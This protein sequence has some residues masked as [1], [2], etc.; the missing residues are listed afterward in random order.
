M[1]G[2]F[3]YLTWIIFKIVQIEQL[4][5]LSEQISTI[6]KPELRGDSLTKPPFEVPRFIRM[7]HNRPLPCGV[8][9]LGAWALWCCRL[10]RDLLRLNFDKSDELEK[11]SL[12]QRQRHGDWQ[13]YNLFKMYLCCMHHLPDCKLHAQSSWY[14]F[15]SSISKFYSVK[16]GQIIII[17]KVFCKGQSTHE[18]LVIG[19]G[20]HLTHEKNSQNRLIQQY[21]PSMNPSLRKIWLNLNNYTS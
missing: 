9:F 11:T 19:G 13:V 16:S 8:V 17:P 6:P 15:F 14:V 5:H 2:S 18:W 4:H 1:V 10:L 12:T 21:K 7:S 3:R 20:F